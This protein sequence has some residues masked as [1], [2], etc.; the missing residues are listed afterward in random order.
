MQERAH[1]LQRQWKKEQRLFQKQ[2]AAYLE[3]E[4]GQ[5]ARHGRWMLLNSQKSQAEVSAEAG[6]QQVPTS[7]RHTFW[8][9]ETAENSLQICLLAT[10]P[11]VEDLVALEQ[12][13]RCK[14]A[15]ASQL[16]CLQATLDQRQ[17]LLT[18]W[19]YVSH[20]QSQGEQ[21]FPVA[22]QAALRPS[23]SEAR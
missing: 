23:E 16:S 17:S 3:V 11:S 13:A 6:L 1:L 5:K 22:R 10:S 9:R 8:G 21:R 14:D 7:F 2:Q 19:E 4:R 15:L 18:Q 12:R 20:Q